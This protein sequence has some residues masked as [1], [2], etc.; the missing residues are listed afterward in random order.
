MKEKET[1]ILDLTGCKYLLEVHL[2]IKEAF[3]FPD[4]YGQNWSAFWDLLWSECTADKVKI[5]GEEKLPK[6]FE[7]QLVIM[8][9]ILE[10]LKEHRAECGEVFDYEI[11][12]ES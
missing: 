2:R 5:I 4:F 9:G 8:H 7:P 1:I 12:R 11:V 6:E 10:R 3:H